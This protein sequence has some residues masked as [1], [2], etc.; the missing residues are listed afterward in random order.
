ML[1]VEGDRCKATVR[2]EDVISRDGCGQIIMN[3]SYGN[4][5]NFLVAFRSTYVI[6]LR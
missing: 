2:I 6:K 4:D 5:N 3:E 1:V